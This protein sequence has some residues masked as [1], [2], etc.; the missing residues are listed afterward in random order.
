MALC[1]NYWGFSLFH[2]ISNLT[3]K[4]GDGGWILD[5]LGE[6]NRMGIKSW[7]MGT[8]ELVL[9][10]FQRNDTTQANSIST[11]KESFDQDLARDMMGI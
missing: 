6:V 2:V 4:N 3:K 7:S 5:Q 8:S 10:I 9:S 11:S 1:I